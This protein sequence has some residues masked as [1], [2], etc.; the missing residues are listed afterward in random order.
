[1]KAEV[2]EMVIFSTKNGVADKDV[3]ARSQAINSVLRE[4]GGFI[5][6]TFCQRDDGKWVDIVYWDNLDNARR[7]AE[8][9]MKDDICMSFF[10]LIDQQDMDF[11]H[12]HIRD[13]C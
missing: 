9:V 13:E 3:L 6:R 8:Y 12:L 11:R 7:A 5:H 2:V 10:K 1:M 4:Q